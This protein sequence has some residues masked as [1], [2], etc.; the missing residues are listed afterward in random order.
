MVEK[1]MMRSWV[2]RRFVALDCD[3]QVVDLA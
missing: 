3:I 1:A 2:S